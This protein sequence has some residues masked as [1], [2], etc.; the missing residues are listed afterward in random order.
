VDEA[1][2]LAAACV[3]ARALTAR[4]TADPAACSCDAT[5][6]VLSSCNVVILCLLQTLFEDK[7]TGQMMSAVDCY[8]QCQVRSSSSSPLLCSSGLS[9]W[10]FTGRLAVAQQHDSS[11]HTHHLNN[12]GGAIKRPYEVDQ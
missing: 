6:A 10:N 11:C 2:L 3:L 8:F 5:P 4:I 1:C 12:S 9:S 7:D